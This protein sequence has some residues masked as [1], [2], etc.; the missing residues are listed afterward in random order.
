[1]YVFHCLKFVHITIFFELD[2]ANFFPKKTLLSV[3]VTRKN[4][5]LIWILSLAMLFGAVAGQ[6]D[7]RA[8]TDGSSELNIPSTCELRCCGRACCLT[9]THNSPLFLCLCLP[10]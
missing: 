10:P 5:M 1:M 2:V 8:P 9:D 3:N 4:T 7:L 6:C